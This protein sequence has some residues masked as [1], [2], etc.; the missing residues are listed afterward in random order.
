MRDLSS[1][2]RTTTLA[3][4]LLAILAGPARAACSD[5]AP[6]VSNDLSL[7]CLVQPRMDAPDP[8]LREQSKYRTLLSELSAVMGMP[9]LEPADTVGF[10]GFHFSFDTTVTSINKGADYWSGTPDPNTGLRGGAGVRRVT[11]DLLPVLS[12]TL[13]KGVWLPLPPLPSVE[14]GFGASNLVNSG[15][16]GLNGYLKLAIHEGYHDVF[17]PSLAV[18]AS[19]T[20]IAGSSEIDM[21]LINLDG[22]LSKA[23]GVGGTVTLEPY[24]GGGVLFSIVRGQVIDTQADLDLYRG[25]PPPAPP[26]DDVG[27]A[28]ALAR[29]ISFPTQDDIL[30]WRLFAGLHVHYSILAL[31]GY[32]AYIGPGAD[33]N[34]NLDALRVGA[35]PKDVAAAQYQFAFSLGL[36][37]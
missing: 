18:R 13:R 14:L 32:F 26:L 19:V 2:A 21:T 25:Q 5:Q 4:L 15:L 31:T 8:N 20:R 7:E 34:F 33:G 36:R 28:R 3:G 6:E 23:F 35:K 11:G 22:V 30:R 9:M 1:C 16:Y 37:F 12:V 24:L 29:K 17:V 27:R 10:T